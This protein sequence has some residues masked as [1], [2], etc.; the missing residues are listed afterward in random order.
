MLLAE[1]TAMGIIS[2]GVI[3]PYAPELVF[4]SAAKDCPV[5]VESPTGLEHSTWLDFHLASLAPFHLRAC[6]ATKTNKED[7][8]SFSFALH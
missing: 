7:E 3:D 5:R 8:P 4:S 6:S 2:W 1:I